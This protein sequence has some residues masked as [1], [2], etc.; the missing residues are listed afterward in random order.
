MLRI[1][2]AGDPYL[3]KLLVQSAHY[4]LGPYGPDTDLRRFGE[5]L[6][7]RGGR[8]AKKKATV[9]VAR[10]LAVLLHRLWVTAEAYEPL[11]HAHRMNAAAE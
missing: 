6:I 2:K 1:T 11:R 4:I 3:R 8:A 5:R 9:A 7:A 10:K